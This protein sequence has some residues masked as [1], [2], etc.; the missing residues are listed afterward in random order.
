MTLRGTNSTPGTTGTASLNNS[1]WELM[2]WDMNATAY[3]DFI[4]GRDRVVTLGS[5]TYDASSENEAWQYGPRLWAY[6]RG[7]WTGLNT[8]Y[9]IYPGEHRW[10]DIGQQIGTGP[11]INFSSVFS[12]R[13]AL[14]AYN[15]AN[16]N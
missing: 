11:V 14:N 15:G 4:L 13:P 12:S 5:N 8:Q 3:I 16:T 2:T 9:P 1:T 6:H 7:G 10:L